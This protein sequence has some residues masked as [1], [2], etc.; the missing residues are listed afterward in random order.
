M[1]ILVD[2]SIKSPNAP[3]NREKSKKIDSNTETFDAGKD[4]SV[5]KSDG[6]LIP[7]AVST[8][9]CTTAGD[10]VNV[11]TGSFY[12]EAV[13]LVIEDRGMDLNITRRYYSIESNVGIMGM[14]WV[15]EYQTHLKIDGDKISLVYPDGHIKEFKKIDSVW[16]NQTD[17][18][19]SDIL[20]KDSAGFI[21]TTGKN[22]TY[23]YECAKQSLAVSVGEN[24]TQEKASHHPVTVDLR[25][26][27]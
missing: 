23:K 15:V 6:E 26:Y 18:D 25:P 8:D 3:E 14:G 20:M 17:E 13:D 10:P 11:A 4:V 2:L 12:I 19:R 7:N 21:L 9:K 27:W 24:L 16:T 5:P 22:L 1:E